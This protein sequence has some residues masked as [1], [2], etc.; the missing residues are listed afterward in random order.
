MK[1][2]IFLLLL[3]HNTLLAQQRPSNDSCNAPIVLTDVTSWC[4]GTDAY[5]NSNTVPTSLDAPTFCPTANFTNDVWFSFTAEALVVNISVTATGARPFLALYADTCGSMMLAA[6]CSNGS[7]NTVDLTREGLVPG[8]T[9]LVRVGTSTAANFSLCINNYNAPV[10][11]GSDCVTAAFLCDKSSFTIRSITSAGSVFDEARGTCLGNE[12]G[13]SSE[14][15]STWFKWVCDAPGTL[16]F[17]LTPNNILADLDFVV[18]EM[19]YGVNNCQRTVLR[20]NAAGGDNSG[21]YACSGAT[22]LSLTDTDITEPP[23]CGGGNNRFVKALDMVAGHAYI[24]M[25]N[26]YSD[27]DTGFRI[28]FGGTGTFLG[29]KANFAVAPMRTCV[30]NA[31]TIT[32]ASVAGL[33]TITENTYY[34]GNGAQPTNTATGVGPHTIT[35]NAVGTKPIIHIIRSSEGC[36]TSKTIPI[37]I[38]TLAI[39]ATT[40]PPTCG[41]GQDGGAT[42]SVTRGIV[43]YAFVWSNGS[44]TPT[45]QNVVEGIYT[46]T[47]SDAGTCTQTA[48]IP[49]SELELIAA[50]NTNTNPLCTNTPSGTITMQITNGQPPYTFDFGNSGTFGASPNFNNLTAGIYTIIAQDGNRCTTPFTFTLADPPLLVITKTDS[51]NLKCF[52]DKSG[53]ARV[54]ATGG[55]PSYTYNWSIPNSTTTSMV[56]LDATTY[57]VTATD[58]NN[59]TETATFALTQPPP[60]AINRVFVRNSPC[61]NQNKGSLSLVDV[62]GGTLPYTFSANCTAYQTDS[63]IQNLFAGNYTVCVKDAEGCTIS[64]TAN[65]AQPLPIIVDAGK[66]VTIDLGETTTLS[67]TAT[68]LGS[69]GDYSWLPAEYL[70]CADCKTTRAAPVNTTVYTVKLTNS[71]GCVYTDTVTVYIDSVRPVFIPNIFTPNGDGKNDIFQPFANNSVR[72]IKSFKVFD[73]WGELVYETHDAPIGIN[74]IGGTGWDGFLKN[75]PLNP[76]VFVYIIELNFIDGETVVYKGD[77][78]LAY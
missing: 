43:P 58:A 34:F 22:G 46:V 52:E 4:S 37:L 57:T 35:Y 47:V 73:R 72:N 66:A 60:I 30:G 8:T 13:Q 5:N 51:T 55:T 38:D 9:Y 45:I 41:G 26:N 74:G 18:W 6:D 33:G 29:P 48:E 62:A 63:L 56:G 54:L 36:V 1:K 10:T 16:S 68:P 32:D 64:A 17:T 31:V 50:A 24:V 11:P 53:T 19:D 40:I 20:C 70:S 7:G 25:V 75:K 28:D 65:I 15:S 44:T 61:Y 23:G 49:V 21:Q 77:V 39:T 71:Y 2:I 78:T 76:A 69:P 67:A 42:V 12:P 59:C 3:L 27:G 14:F